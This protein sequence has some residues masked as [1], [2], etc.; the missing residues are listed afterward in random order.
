VPTLSRDVLPRMRYGR[1]RQT[2]L[3]ALPAPH[4]ASARTETVTFT[5]VPAGPGGIYSACLFDDTLF[6][7]TAV[8][9]EYA[10][11]ASELRRRCR[12]T[13]ARASS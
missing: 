13:I 6:F 9:R 7:L 3:P 10:G 11:T 2:R 4:D 8:A 12:A 1:G 5:T